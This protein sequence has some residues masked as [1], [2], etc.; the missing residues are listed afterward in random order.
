MGEFST[1]RFVKWAGGKGQLI[2]QFIP[3]FPKKINRYI[4]PFVGG[5]AVLFYIIQN[6]HPKEIIIS[7]VNKELITTY[8]VIKQDV[9]KLIS[10]LREHKKHHSKDY[11]YK[12]RAILP[13]S[14]SDVDKAARFIY[15]NKTCFNGLYRVNSKGGFNVPMGQYKN[16]DIVQE[17][18]L[19]EISKLLKNVTIK[20]ESFENVL[21]YSKKGDFVYFDPPYYPL[22]NKNSFTTY[23]HD[24]F[25]DNEHK[26]LAEVFDALSKKGCFVMESNSDTG[27]VR[28]L[29]SKYAIKLVRATRMI[30][31]R[32]EDRGLINEIVIRNY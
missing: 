20:C 10:I 12:I 9:E 4:E 16:P 27:F 32:S 7:D 17:N 30:N 14:L 13:S 6:Y 18:K 23:H 3:L 26:K 29:Y 25:L 21:S 11:Y 5:G 22:K 19:R 31:C 24:V 15:L 1:I 28:K 8:N 2:E